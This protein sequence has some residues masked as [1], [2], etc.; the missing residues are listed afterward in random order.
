MLPTF[1]QEG[2]LGN[3]RGGDYQI[4]IRMGREQ[5]R[6]RKTG[7]IAADYRGAHTASLRIRRGTYNAVESLNSVA[8]PSM[9]ANILTMLLLGSSILPGQEP[10][11]YFRINVVDEH[12]GRGVPLVEL[13]TVNG[14][15]HVTDSA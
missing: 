13:R 3:C 10:R 8:R 15:V 1:N 7:Q 5:Q 14:I 12:S 11:Q 6:S 9:Y 2:G 4:N